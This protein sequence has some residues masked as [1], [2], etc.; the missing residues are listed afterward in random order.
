M[1]G[2]GWS[3]QGCKE[4]QLPPEGTGEPLQVQSRWQGSGLYI[5]EILM[6]GARLR[7]KCGVLEGEE[8][9][10]EMGKR[11]EEGESRAQR[12]E[13]I[14]FLWVEGREALGCDP[15]VGTGSWIWGK[16]CCGLGGPW[17]M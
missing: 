14:G 8:R 12:V 7:Q 6:A 11:G 1:G 10:K 3:T 4:P 17:G 15:R 2:W 9:E 16:W 5:T 13:F